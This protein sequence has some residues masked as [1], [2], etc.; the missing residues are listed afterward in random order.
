MKKE[1]SE[2]KK[3]EALLD[4]SKI[5][6]PEFESMDRKDKFKETKKNLKF[7]VKTHTFIEERPK[8]WKKFESRGNK[9][10][11]DSDSNTCYENVLT[12][13]YIRSFL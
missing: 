12:M 9:G 5:R 1:K 3:S 4:P 10:K 7:D 2:T 6:N 8:N 13:Q 11:D